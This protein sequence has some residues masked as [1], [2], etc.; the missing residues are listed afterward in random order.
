M[1]FTPKSPPARLDAETA[2]Y[3]DDLENRIGDAFFSGEL[4]FLSLQVLYVAPDKPTEG[5]V[6][7]ADGTYWDPGSG[8]GFYGYLNGAYTKLG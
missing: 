2:D 5:G 3:L 8:A 6:Y 1:S 4:N 7:C